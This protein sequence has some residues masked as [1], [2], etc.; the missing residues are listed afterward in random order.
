V[1]DTREREILNR[2][3]S[4]SQY[5]TGHKTFLAV[6]LPVAVKY[7]TGSQELLSVLREI[8]SHVFSYNIVMKRGT[9]YNSSMYKL[10]R[11]IYWSQYEEREFNETFSGQITWDGVPQNASI[12]VQEFKDDVR[13]RRER[14]AKDEPFV[15]YLMSEDILNGDFT[16]GWGGIRYKDSLK[17]LLYEYERHLQEQSESSDMSSFGYWVEN[18]QLEHLVPQNGLDESGYDYGNKDKNKLGNLALLSP[19]ENNRA[20]NKQYRIKQPVIYK[21]SPVHMLAEL[22]EGELSGDQ[23]DARTRR[24]AEF[25]ADRW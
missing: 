20:S 25:A 24:L 1:E 12:A 7:G 8:E 11:D 18:Y 17:F 21:S 2:L 5:S 22:P 16:D 10:G 13:N 19:S 3:Y 6:L 23:I 15:E 14:K 4:L 9:S